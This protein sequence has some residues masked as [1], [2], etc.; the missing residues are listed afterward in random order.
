MFYFD[1]HIYN[2]LYLHVHVALLPSYLFRTKVQ[3]TF[4]YFRKYFRTS[5]F[6]LRVLQE[7]VVLPYFRTCTTYE[8][9]S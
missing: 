8:S 2:V 3:R 4:T 5:V 6:Y 1:N 9:T 7:V